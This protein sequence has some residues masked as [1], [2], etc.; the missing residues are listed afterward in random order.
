MFE[1][2]ILKQISPL[3]SQNNIKKEMCFKIKKKI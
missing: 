3:S 1:F 2:D